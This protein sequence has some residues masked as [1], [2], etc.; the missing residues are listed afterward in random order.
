M[1]EYFRKPNVA[2]SYSDMLDGTS[3]KQMQV[4]DNIYKHSELKKPYESSSYDDMEQMW[5]PSFNIPSI[6][7]T[8]PFT[9]VRYS[10]HTTP[11]RS[12]TASN[13]GGIN[14]TY[15][16][17]NTKTT[18]KT[19][20]KTTKGSIKNTYYSMKNRTII[21]GSGN[22][23]ELWK[24]M[25]GSWSGGF[26][27]ATAAKNVNDYAKQ[28]SVIFSPPE[29]CCNGTSISTSNE[30]VKPADPPSGCTYSWSKKLVSKSGGTCTYKMEANTIWSD[31]PCASKTVSTP[32]GDSIHAYGNKFTVKAIPCGGESIGYV[33]QQM[34]VNDI[35]SLT[36]VNPVSGGSYTWEVTTGGGS[37]TSGGVYTA[38]ATNA[39]CANNPTISLKC[40]GNVMATLALAVNAFTGDPTLHATRTWVDENCYIQVPG[41]PPWVICEIIN[42]TYNCDGVL[43]YGPCTAGVACQPTG[44]PCPDCC[45]VNISGPACY[46][47]TLSPDVLSAASP[48]DLRGAFYKSLGCCPA[49]LL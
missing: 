32:C 39:E 22:C 5:Q 43:V 40:G 1:R 21:R 16:S 28:C 47:G 26:I 24:S 12:R 34:G 30:F 17:G 48:I 49:Q 31:K 4:Q 36:V 18:Y 13:A 27:D 8:T 44:G 35:Q 15:S 3:E 25:F 20:I 2:K 23:F 46:S 37:I 33:S 14:T 7:S 38:P 41:S 42:K 19:V 6:P 9:A 45:S 29:D 11:G 10:A